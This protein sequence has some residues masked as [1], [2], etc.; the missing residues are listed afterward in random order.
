MSVRIPQLPFIFNM[1]KQW[2]YTNVGDN[3]WIVE[4]VFYNASNTGYV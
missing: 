1:V 3:K 4:Y 2:L